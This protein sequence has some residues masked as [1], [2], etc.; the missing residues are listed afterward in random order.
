MRPGYRSGLRWT[1]SIVLIL[2]W[3]AVGCKRSPEADA[4][5]HMS[6]GIQRAQSGDYARAILEFRNAARSTPKDPAPYYRVALC[7]L[8]LDEAPGAILNL[9]KAVDLNPDFLEAQL[10][11]A[12]MLVA[13]R[14]PEAVALAVERLNGT[15]ARHPGHTGALELRAQAELALGKID[16]ADRTLAQLPGEGRH[17]N[18]GRLRALVEIGRKNN[19]AAEEL[20]KEGYAREPNSADAA[21]A[22]GR[23]YRIS[24]RRAEAEARF[25]EALRIDGSNPQALMDLATLRIE[26]GRRAEARGLFEKLGQLP[27]PRYKLAWVRYL[28]ESGDTAGAMKTLEGLFRQFP[29]DRAVRSTLVRSYLAQNRPA[30]ARRVLDRAL[31][32]NHADADALG[33]RAELN[34]NE[35]RPRQAQEDLMNLLHSR[36]ESGEAHFLLSR[37]YRERGLAELETQEL[38][39]AVSAS[40]ELLPARIALAQ[41]LLRSGEPR[42][43]LEL[44]NAAPGRQKNTAPALVER[45]W[46]LLA[47]GQR[48]EAREGID[49][50]LASSDSADLALQDALLKLAE[51]QAEPAI[52]RLDKALARWPED[53]R[54]LDVLVFAHRARKQEGQGIE[55]VRAHA[56]A[57]PQAAAVHQYLGEVLAA[58]GEAAGARAALEKARAAGGRWKALAGVQ[59]ARLDA[60]AGSRAAA[61]DRLTDILAGDRDNRAARRLLAM[62]EQADGRAS[63]AVKHYQKLLAFDDHD[64]IALNNLAWLLAE[65]EQQP[66][67]ALRYAQRAR[68][69]SPTPMPAIDDTLGRIYY[70]KGLYRNAI[71][72]FETALKKQSNAERTYHLALAYLKSGQK[73]RAE[74]TYETALRLNPSLPA[75][76]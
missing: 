48:A 22:L 10:K 33:Q 65:H 56:A 17:G 21:L 49:R 24:G 52:A 64:P 23:F 58:R 6:A 39:E 38:R 69:L 46:S 28:A 18:A 75:L 25:R 45:N 68:E 14:R 41:V 31:E 27:Q 13:T 15:L 37:V 19:N 72:Y 20:L 44:M 5:L 16:D 50:A 70:H 8:E 30:D 26:D 12:D 60:Q 35:G 2:A 51:G 67:L 9:R 1:A 54:I 76:Q 71:E 32:A 61:R 7:Y 36:P 53:I 57:H 62:V 11:L 55:R 73:A 40:P 59:L 4:A 66:D 3:G 42:A 47:L 34:L 29:R 74:R 63:E 43:A